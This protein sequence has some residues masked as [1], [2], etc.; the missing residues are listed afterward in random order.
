MAT[1]IPTEPYEYTKVSWEGYSFNC[2]K[3]LPDNYYVFHSFKMNQVNPET[4]D[5][6]RHEMD[7]LIF[8]PALGILCIEQKHGNTG[9]IVY[10]DGQWYFLQNKEGK[11]I[12]GTNAMK[13]GGPFR[14]AE[15]R[16]EDISEY[17]KNQ[18]IKLDGYKEKSLKKYCKVTYAV[19]FPGMKSTDKIEYCYM[20][21]EG[22]KVEVT[23]TM[24]E[25]L[26]N[27]GTPKELVIFRDDLEDPVR[28]KDKIDNIFRYKMYLP[29]PDKESNSDVR[30]ELNA[31]IDD[32][33]DKLI[34]E[35]DMSQNQA[36]HKEDLENVKML[37]QYLGS[38]KYKKIRKGAEITTGFNGNPLSEKDIKNLFDFVLCPHY[39]IVET[40]DSNSDETKFIRLNE[41]QIH[42]L[43]IL[44]TKKV[45]AVSGWAGTGK[46]I[47]AI[48][49]AKRKKNVLFLC[50]NNLMKEVFEKQYPNKQITFTDIDSFAKE[51]LYGVL[52][53]GEE[54]FSEDKKRKLRTNIEEKLKQYETIII[55]EGQD[56]NDELKSIILYILYCITQGIDDT[57]NRSQE[58]GTLKE[59]V[60]R[61]LKRSDDSKQKSFYFFYDEFQT[62]GDG[63]LP[64]FITDIKN[65]F[66]LDKN[67]RNSEN[68]VRTAFKPIT[69]NNLEGH[70][71]RSAG[72]VTEK[73]K[74]DFYDGDDDLCKHLHFILSQ[75][76]PEE[77]VI[78]TCN[79]NEKAVAERLTDRTLLK[80]EDD[81]INGFLF[82]SWKKFKGLEKQNVVLVDFDPLAFLF[83]GNEA[84]FRHFYV[85]IT[86]AQEMVYLLA[87]LKRLDVVHY[88]SMLFQD[89][90]IDHE[91]MRDNYLCRNIWITPEF[92]EE[93]MSKGYQ[94]FREQFFEKMNSEFVNV[95]ARVIDQ[96]KSDI[97]TFATRQAIADVLCVENIYETDVLRAASVDDERKEI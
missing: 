79:S 74:I 33:F 59:K 42:I 72:E 5:L 44:K 97:L 22:K 69:D 95:I 32:Q 12:K 56:Y 83:S 7:F 36:I 52:L 49:I 10:Q 30:V 43:E 81:K 25:M 16:K 54:V 4:G 46:T 75:L 60:E 67:Y 88:C 84:Y 27:P 47:L 96:D 90:N 24:T 63:K 80:Y 51:V 29:S 94:E 76:N 53:E 15:A 86:R 11:L 23:T 17:I 2:F 77:T 13:Y 58:K 65:H 41:D 38:L 64:S 14:Q 61:R 78:L 91:T 39:N 73:V 31:Q 6:S 37:P 50:I 9:K 82:T 3:K 1:M 8:H 48:E 92:K 66:E 19:C 45:M 28:L 20:T 87:P 34:F 62:Y 89:S 93:V 55:D 85:G 71:K 18:N 57:I 35:N 40:L 68:I 70:C 21:R 26:Q